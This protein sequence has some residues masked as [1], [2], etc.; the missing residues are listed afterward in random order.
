MSD[1][2]R[3]CQKEF[4]I[5]KKEC[6]R[7]QKQWGLSGWQVYFKFKP[8]KDNFAET[9]A[10]LESRKATITLS[11]QLPSDE[12]RTR[13]TRE[14]AMHEMLH[15]LL[16]RV[17]ALGFARWVTKVELEEAEHELIQQLLKIIP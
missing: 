4:T 6:L 9:D 7:L 15:V 16:W 13:N 17:S 1:T 8:L 5:F 2:K 12:Y 10:N 11:S 3:V 14:T